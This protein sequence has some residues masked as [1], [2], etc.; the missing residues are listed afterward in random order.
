MFLLR[1]AAANGEKARP[2]RSRPPPFR[3]GSNLLVGVLSVNRVFP[4]LIASCSCRW[5]TTY[6]LFLSQKTAYLSARS[7]WL[8]RQRANLSQ[9]PFVRKG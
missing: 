5:E 9:S 1:S 3:V 2:T 7:F 6:W 4:N 8:A